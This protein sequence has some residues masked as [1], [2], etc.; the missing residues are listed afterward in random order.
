MAKI[1]SKE[2]RDALFG[3]APIAVALR[4]MAIPAVVAQL[5]NLVYNMAD[6]Y[7]VGRTGD[8]Y[9]IAAISLAFPLFMFNLPISGLFGI[10]GGSYIARLLGIKDYERIGKVSAFCFFGA[11]ALAIVYSVSVLVYMEPLLV[12]LGASPS[13]IVF[14]KQYVTTVVVIGNLPTVLSAALSHML[15]NAGYS[16]QASF[17]LSMGGVMNMILDPLFMF[18]LLPDGYQV[19]G[20]AAATTV[21]NISALIYFIAVFN[22]T[23]KE[24]GLSLDPKRV[25]IE[26]KDSAEIFKVGIP[27][28]MTTLLMDLSNMYLNASMAAHGD[29]ELAA[30]GIEMKIERLSNAICLGIA[31]GVMPLA[32][33]NYA[34]RNDKR[35]RAFLNT[36]RIT[37]LVVA[38]VSVIF[39]QT[40][41]GTLISAFISS[42]KN[43]AEV[44]KTV[45]LG[46][47]FL[48]VRSL[49]APFVM[50]N[51]VST[52]GFQATGDGRLALLQT[53]VRQIVLYLPLLYGFDLFF[54]EIGLV[55]AYPTTELLSGSVSSLLLQMKLKKVEEEHANSS[56]R[57][58][59]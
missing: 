35:L 48:R 42:G 22:K 6:A 37:G 20:A 25:F 43:A 36:A 11:A 39:Y 40:M 46:I 47:V 16:K 26:K 21:S 30:L 9:M 34:V 3:S 50:L 32:A 12:L 8:P 58:I 19:L 1:Q 44:A 13:T 55:A 56:I 23:K 33:Y 18:V 7:F 27:S 59:I 2:E 41:A 4:T 15:R 29:L 51:F 17:G 53:F 14:A 38:I 45:S 54:G 52:S 5:I 28:A 57:H 10:G 24:T 31:Q 49:A